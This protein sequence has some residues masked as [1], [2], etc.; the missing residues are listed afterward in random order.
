MR[1]WGY[2]TPNRGASIVTKASYDLGR[3]QNQQSP[4]MNGKVTG[5]V[6][7]MGSPEP[8]MVEGLSHKFHEHI[9]E[10]K[11]NNMTVTKSTSLSSSCYNLFSRDS[12]REQSSKFSIFIL[13]PRK[14]LHFAKSFPSTEQEY[15][16]RNL[17]K[18]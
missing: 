13:K 9:K 8:A 18:V 10:T 12:R 4:W 11:Y 2:E 14:Y 16:M 3:T 7:M 5:E 15:I 1:W 17:V 6:Q